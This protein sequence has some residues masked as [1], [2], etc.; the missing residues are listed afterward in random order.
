[1]FKSSL[2]L[3]L[4]LC[5]TLP[6][7]AQSFR[8][9]I[10]WYNSVQGSQHDKESLI[11]PSGRRL[12]TPQSKFQSDFRLNTKYTWKNGTRLVIRPRLLGD[13]SQYHYLTPEE[14]VTKYSGEASMP[15]AYL[16]GDLTRRLSVAVG[17]QNYQWGPAEFI[18]PTN[19]FYH[20][21]RD[22]RSFTYREDGR[23]L[24]RS[25]WSPSAL[26]SV[27][28]IVEPGNNGQSFWIYEQEFKPK[29][30][31]KVERRGKNALNYFGMAA[32]TL[33]DTIPFIGEYF[34]FELIPGLSVYL[35]ARH[36][37][38]VAQYMPDISPTDLLYDMV[39]V[40]NEKTW[41]SMAAM[42][43]RWEGSVDFR[44][45]YI[46]NSYG[47]EKEEML[48]AFQSAV[49]Q[50][51][52]GDVNLKRILGSGR[53]LMGQH[54]GYASLRMPDLFIQNNNL[55]LRYIQ[56]LMDQSSSA[57]VAWDT[58]IGDAWTL[59]AEANYSF[60]DNT[61]EFSALERASGQLGLKWNL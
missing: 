47:L 58:A 31:L 13:A 45:E 8:W 2:I 1:M 30:L 37:Q 54:Y 28:T 24:L 27:I 36:S 20:F 53:E 26:W 46:Y 55:S 51:P 35:D 3:A 17:L 61:Q 56:S 18:S 49:P 38:G 50:H 23:L 19:P 41:H 14:N 12:N 25:N 10:E 22:Q 4:L 44:M 34:N 39:Y 16:E 48:A 60:G 21:R 33:D 40:R 43:F 59:F 29:G 5:A 42:G 9:D 32:G 11:D 15:E 6:A 52:R 7:A 57:Q